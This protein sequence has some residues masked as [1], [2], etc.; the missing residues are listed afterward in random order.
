VLFATNAVYLAAVPEKR[1]LPLVGS[2][3]E[4]APEVVPGHWTIA[5]AALAFAFWMPLS[6]LAVWAGQAAVGWL[7]SRGSATPAREASMVVGLLLG[8]FLLAAALA[9]AVVRGAAPGARTKNAV[10]GG[11]LAAFFSCGVAAGAGALASWSV[12]AVSVLVLGLAGAAGG[13]L[14]GWIGHRWAERRS[15]RVDPTRSRH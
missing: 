5:M 15:V 7:V 8:S 4:L 3:A 6:L 12:A 13:A 11:V 10:A 2:S 1:R 9:S 14:G